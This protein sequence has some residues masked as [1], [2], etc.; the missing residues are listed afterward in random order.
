MEAFHSPP[1]DIYNMAD[2]EYD[3]DS[4]EEHFYPT[5]S[6]VVSKILYVKTTLLER[7]LGPLLLLI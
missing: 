3:M 2:Y 7:D 4:Y 6:K 1:D 5:H